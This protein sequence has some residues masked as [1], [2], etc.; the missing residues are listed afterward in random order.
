MP[1]YDN[2]TGYTFMGIKRKKRKFCTRCGNRNYSDKSLCVNC[3][4]N[5][6]ISRENY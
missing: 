6:L 3:R 2:V 1:S 4:N 5:D